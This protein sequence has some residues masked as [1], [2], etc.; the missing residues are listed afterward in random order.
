MSHFVY[1]RA[2]FS[3]VGKI[4]S[5]IDTYSSRGLMLKRDEDDISHRIQSF[6]IAELVDNKKKNIVGCGSLYLYN[7][8]L[9]EI[10][11]LAVAELWQNKK[12]GRFLI[13]QL[14]EMANDLNSSSVFAL[15]MKVR[16]FEK[17]GFKQVNKETL[18]DKIWNDCV[19]CL[20]NDNCQETALIYHLA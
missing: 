16:F 2:N 17:L 3:D 10:R 20:Y 12:I 4:K 19:K 7:K 9:S 13:K 14:L 1:R 5:L 11:S 18:P 15:T 6:A 8:H